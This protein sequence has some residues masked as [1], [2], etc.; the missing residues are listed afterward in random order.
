MHNH[1]TINIHCMEREEM[2]TCVQQLQAIP[3]A[4]VVDET[5]NT[6]GNGT[7]GLVLKYNMQIGFE[8][9]VLDAIDKIMVNNPVM[10]DRNLG[11]HPF[12]KKQPIESLSFFFL[13][14]SSS[15]FSLN[16]V[17]VYSYQFP[18]ECQFLLYPYGNCSEDT[19]QPIFFLLVWVWV[20]YK[21]TFF[22]FFTF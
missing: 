1:K 9:E 12:H 6:K 20:C 10:Q 7:W 18:Y 8:Q 14:S 3:S 11:H 19:R 17:W 4:I 2:E 13:L 5:V 15:S 16:K 22:I 21:Y